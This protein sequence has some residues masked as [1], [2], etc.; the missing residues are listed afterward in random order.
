MTNSPHEL[1]AKAK[2]ELLAL[3]APEAVRALELG[4][5]HHTGQRNGG[6]PEFTHQLGIFNFLRGFH[7]ELRNPTMVYTLAFLHDVL[8]DPHAGQVYLPPSV[9]GHLFGDE[10]ERKVRALS[11]EMFGEK[12]P[13]YS[14]DLIFDDPDTSV[15]KAADRL[16][17]VTTM[18]GIFKPERL[19]RYVKETK[20]EFI[21]RIN[22]A[23]TRFSDQF[24][25][26]LNI[27]VEL[28]RLLPNL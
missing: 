8:E 15:V 12:N 19:A 5:S 1:I 28:V 26:Y 16:N 7:S 24:R 4:A 23:S 10:V 22:S 27:E 6:A 13:A 11:K 18:V 9:I 17:N 21:P 3:G 25:V 14:L 2:D 20:E